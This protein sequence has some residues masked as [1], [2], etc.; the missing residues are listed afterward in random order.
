MHKYRKI[1]NGIEISV[2]PL[3]LDDRSDPSENYFVWSYTIT[4]TNQSS[5]T[6][7]LLTR[8]WEI[9]DGNGHRQDVDG[10]GVVG[11]QPTLGPGERFEYTSGCPLSTSTGFMS[12]YYTMED[13]NGGMLEVEVPAFSLDS[14]LAIQTLN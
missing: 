3:Y 11:K 7:T 8:H 9:I 4:I 12:G 6:V 13:S 14:P 2:L 10:E 5:L 1:T